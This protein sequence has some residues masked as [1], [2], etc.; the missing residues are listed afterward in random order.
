MPNLNV[1][2]L[3]V[4]RAALQDFVIP[5]LELEPLPEEF[6][7]Q[8]TILREWQ[9]SNQRRVDLFRNNLQ[10]LLRAQ[11]LALKHD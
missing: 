10:S 7:R 4:N 11:L 8:F 1:E 6:V 9:L 3:A 5:R 2:R